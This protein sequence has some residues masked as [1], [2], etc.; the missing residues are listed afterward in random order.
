MAAGTVGNLKRVT[1]RVYATN[2]ED[3]VK[4]KEYDF[5]FAKTI[6]QQHFPQLLTEIDAAV[7]TLNTPLGRGVRPTPA[8]ALEQIFR[9][10]GWLSQQP[11]SPNH[12]HLRFDLKKD[13]VAVEIQL[14]D[15]S[16]CYNDFLKFLLAYNLEMID[17][18][19]E[20]V[21]DDSVR[22]RNLPHL[23]KA[24]QILQDYWRII[25]CPIWVI[26]LEP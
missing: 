15:P 16:D 7:A 1:D 13:R 5:K 8:A 17:V 14:T 9:Q 4:Y 20:I 25:P 21:Y 18:A 10:C 26:G 11:I 6:L 3:Q 2:K 12:P 19:V 22:G 23:S 24:R